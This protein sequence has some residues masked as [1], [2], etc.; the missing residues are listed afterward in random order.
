MTEKM[1][2]K[3]IAKSQIKHLKHH[4]KYIN[5]SFQP[6]I[7]DY[8]LKEFPSSMLKAKENSQA[9]ALGTKGRGRKPQ[10]IR[11][12]YK[13]VKSRYMDTLS[14]LQ[15]KT[16]AEA[17]TRSRTGEETSDEITS[18]HNEN[19]ESTIKENL[20]KILNEAEG[21]SRSVTGGLENSSRSKQAEGSLAE[22]RRTLKSHTRSTQQKNSRRHNFSDLQH[23]HIITQD[24]RALRRR[25]RSSSL[26]IENL[27]T[28]IYIDGKKVD[29]KG[30]LSH[31]QIDMDQ[32]VESG[33]PSKQNS[34]YFHQQSRIRQG[35]E[36]GRG[37]KGRIPA[38]SSHQASIDHEL[39]SSSMSQTLLHSGRIRLGGYSTAGRTSRTDLNKN[40]S[41]EGK[42]ENV[43]GLDGSGVVRNSERS[44]L[45]ATSHIS[46]KNRS[47]IKRRQ[48]IEYRVNAKDVIRFREARPKKSKESDGDEE[49]ETLPELEKTQKSHKLR[50]IRNKSK[51]M[52]SDLEGEKEYLRRM[53]RPSKTSKGPYSNIQSKILETQ[54]RDPPEKEQLKELSQKLTVLKANLY[55]LHRSTHLKS[56]KKAND[57]DSSELSGSQDWNAIFVIH[58]SNN[59]K[60]STSHKDGD[61]DDQLKRTQNFD[62]FDF[63]HPKAKGVLSHQKKFFHRNAKTI[64]EINQLLR[65]VAGSRKS[66]SLAPHRK[67]GG[68]V[69]S[70]IGRESSVVSKRSSTVDYRRRKS[71][72]RRRG[73]SPFK[74]T[75][76]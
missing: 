67:L 23:D 75:L 43:G 24:I 54:K 56:T 17:Q 5:D 68:G 16:R 50:R 46:G 48:Y 71:K 41:A 45:R 19:E 59:N 39:N 11:K 7:I 3:I 70:S 12:N 66:L 73:G 51:T 29:L 21:A 18:R 15:S 13:K 72:R 53:L 44:R 55:N 36:L 37:S 27:E 42:A 4:W 8:N 63:K 10:K 26:A 74:M 31:R 40:S 32:V 58:E 52:K 28:N 62:R 6:Q 30:Y 76:K 9:Y 49:A 1:V 38:L 35:G 69:L 33:A 60:L 34:S 61:G 64:L 14:Q 65:H 20:G 57:Q 22:T 25:F 2:K 47:H